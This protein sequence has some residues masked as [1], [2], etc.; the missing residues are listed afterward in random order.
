[1]EKETKNHTYLDEDVILTVDDEFFFYW[2]VK[3][4]G[5]SVQRKATE[6]E[7]SEYRQEFAYWENQERENQASAN[8]GSSYG[9]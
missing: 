7:A 4:Y 8:Y 5:L 6:K 1:M 9:C 2:E 3:K